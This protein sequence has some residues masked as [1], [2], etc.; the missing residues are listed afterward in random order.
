VD[1]TRSGIFYG[2]D[3]LSLGLLG[4]CQPYDKNAR[5]TFRA[6][7]ANFTR[8]SSFILIRF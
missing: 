8:F 5:P 1:L 6:S 3:V 7:H 2:G 4:L